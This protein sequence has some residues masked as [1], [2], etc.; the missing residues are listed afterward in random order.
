MKDIPLDENSDSSPHGRGSRL[1]SSEDQ[2]NGIESARCDVKK[3]K[4]PSA[5]TGRSSGRQLGDAWKRSLDPSLESQ[6]EKDL[7][8]SSFREMDKE[9]NRKKILERL[10][11][12][13][14]KLRSLRTSVDYLKR[15]SEMKKRSKNSQL[16]KYEMVKRQL[17]EV[18]EAVDHLLVI[19]GHSMK[20]ANENDSG[21]ITGDELQEQAGKESEKINSIQ[22]QIQNINNVLLKMKDQK[23]PKLKGNQMRSGTGVLLRDFIYHSGSRS[24]DRGKKSC[25]CGCATPSAKGE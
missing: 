23:T 16:M 25:F 1:S 5:A 6:L 22:F 20:N 2:I 19:N 3:Q 18:E 24:G 12:D 13:A 17:H 15:K 14:Q 9:I 11:S 10:T 4:P 8:I 21:D 7:P